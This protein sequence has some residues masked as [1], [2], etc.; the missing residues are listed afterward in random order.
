MRVIDHHVSTT[1]FQSRASADERAR[2]RARDFLNGLSDP[3]SVRSRL[4][5]TGV[6]VWPSISVHAYVRALCNDAAHAPW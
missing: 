2:Y 1:K 4:H 6:P 5:T 3:C